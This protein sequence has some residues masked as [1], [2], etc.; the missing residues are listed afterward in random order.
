[1]NRVQLFEFHDLAAFPSAWR[2]MLT[3]IM[4]FFALRFHVFRPII[5][6]LAQLARALDNPRLVDLC[7]GAGGP[8]LAVWRALGSGPERPLPIV[9][10]DKYP[11]LAAFRRAAQVT[12]GAVSYIE[13][14]VDATDVPSALCGFRTLFASFHHFRP[15]TAQAI[16]GDAARKGQGIGVFEYT[17][18]NLLV[19]ALPILLTPVF[20]WIVTP[21]LRPLTWRRVLWTYLVPVVPIT[22]LWDGLV[23]CL[24]TYSAQELRDLTEDIGCPGYTWESG[25]VRSFGACHVTYLLGYALRAGVEPAAGADDSA[26]AARHN[27]NTSDIDWSAP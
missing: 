21:F 14:P 24:R 25:R 18:R 15:A 27:P 22:G 19:W 23:S 16:L 1:V 2:D 5:P 9:L 12:G 20:C 6:K 3:D 8:A 11:N 13:E 26:G 17:E 7:S 10:T 4:S